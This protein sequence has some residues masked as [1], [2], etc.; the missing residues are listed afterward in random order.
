MSGGQNNSR[1]TQMIYPNGRA[2]DDVYNTGL[3]SSISRLSS[4]ADDDDGSPGTTLEA[5]SYLGLD[6]IVQYAHP[7][8]GINLTY[9]Q[10]TGE[11]DVDT[12]GGDQYVGLDRFGD[13]VDQNWWD[14][15]TETSTDRFQYGYDNDGDVLYSNN[16]VNSAEGGVKRGRS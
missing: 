13:V 14:P 15:T 8:D 10:Q 2:V 9:I 1:Q 6:T 12:D 7:Q 16:L 11:T 4:I 5:Y 3:D